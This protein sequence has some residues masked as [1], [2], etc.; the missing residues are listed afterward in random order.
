M[1][2]DRQVHFFRKLT[3]RAFLP[4]RRRLAKPLKHKV[5]FITRIRVHEPNENGLFDAVLHEITDLC[6]S[7]TC[8]PSEKMIICQS[9]RNA[10]SDYTDALRARGLNVEHIIQKLL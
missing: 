2:G 7:F 1:D 4:D 10:G 3:F 5:M 8:Y 6:D 9:N